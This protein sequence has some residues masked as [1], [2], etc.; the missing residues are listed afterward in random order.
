MSAVT[1]GRDAGGY[2]FTLTDRE[3]DAL[4][5]IADRYVSAETLYDGASFEPADDDGDPDYHGDWVVLVPEPVAWAYVDA[6]ENDEDGS[7]V[8]PPCAGGPLA[9]KLQAFYEAIV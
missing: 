8:V 1:F 4:A 2:T 3:R 6:L 9:D 5:W 7:P